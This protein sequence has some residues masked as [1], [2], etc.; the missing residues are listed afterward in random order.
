MPPFR[1]HQTR[2]RPERILVRLQQ[3]KYILSSQLAQQQ[4]TDSIPSAAVANVAVANTVAKPKNVISLKQIKQIIGLLQNSN[5]KQLSKMLSPEL[6]TLLSIQDE[7]VDKVE[8]LEEDVENVENV[9]ELEL[10]DDEDLLIID[11]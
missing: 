10:D 9:D 11:V 8:E 6:S 7:D 1:I 5:H 3:G 2:I 4:A